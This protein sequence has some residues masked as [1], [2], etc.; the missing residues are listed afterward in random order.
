M[1]DNTPVY[2]FTIPSV[3]DGTLLDCRLYHPVSLQDSQSAQQHT[4]KAALIAHPYA[5]L[6]GSMDDSVVMTVVDQLLDLD[7]VVGTFNFRY[8][9]S[10]TLS[11]AAGTEYQA[12]APQTLMAIPAG[13][14][15]QSEMTI[16][17]LLDIYYSTSIKYTHYQPMIPVLPN[18]PLG[19][20]QVCLLNT[21]I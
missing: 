10:R 21:S 11:I 17:R 5:P 2:C 16:S 1:T 12:G 18:L 8:A 13:L 15:K 9:S 3:A 14:A 4:R 7:F 6:G 19:V 20:D